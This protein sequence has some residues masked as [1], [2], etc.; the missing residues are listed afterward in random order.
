MSE[1]TRPS[2]SAGAVDHGDHAVDRDA[3]LHRRPLEGLDQRLGQSQAGGLDQDVVDLRRQRQDL[4][5]RRARNR[6]RRCSRCSHWPVRRCFPP[7]RCRCR[8]LCRISP[9]M[10]ISPNSLT[11][12]AMR[13]PPAFS[14]RWRISVVLPAPRKPVTTV[15]GTRETEAVM[16]QSFS[17]SRGGMRA[18]RPRLRESGRPRQGMRPS[19]EVAKSF[20]PV[21]R[22]APLVAVRSPKT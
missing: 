5:E 7:G 10:P 18:T 21:T 8:S 6:R 14:S 16:D 22:S 12:M 4:V 20:A 13:L 2:A 19:V 1:A 3:A 15:Q 11:M 17:M 9:S